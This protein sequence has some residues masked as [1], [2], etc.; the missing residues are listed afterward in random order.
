MYCCLFKRLYLYFERSN[1]NI[2]SI[3]R[4]TVPGLQPGKEYVFCVKSVSEAGLS[5]S[6]P[7][8]DP[9]VVRQAI[10]K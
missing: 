5:E 4:F 3:N 10:G 9:I 1:T 7:E 6:S 8:T 2:L